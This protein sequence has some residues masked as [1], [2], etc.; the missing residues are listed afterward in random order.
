[1]FRIVNMYGGQ[2]STSTS[3]AKAGYW[4]LTTIYSSNQTLSENRN[5]VING[6]RLELFNNNSPG[7]KIYTSQTSAEKDMRVLKTDNDGNPVDKEGNLLQD[8]APE[9]YYYAHL[10]E[11]GD[12]FLFTQPSPKYYRYEGIVG[13]EPYYTD[14]CT[15]T[16]T[17]LNEPLG[18]EGTIIDLS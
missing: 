16:F 9:V 1:M 4:D 7:Y 17:E 18:R 12:Y 6:C 15:L 13:T 14:E 11:V 5:T 10:P 8:G 2:E 3:R